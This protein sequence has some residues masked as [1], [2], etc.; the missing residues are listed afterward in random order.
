MKQAGMI[1]AV[2]GLLVCGSL[3]LFGRTEMAAGLLVGMLGSA[4]YFGLMWRQL[5]KNRDAA[6]EEAVAEL[7]GGWVERALYMGAVCGIAWFIPGV[8]FAGVLIG[9]LSMH[10]AVFVWGLVALAKSRRRR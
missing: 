8:Q 6:P 4:G 2:L 1:C 9:L 3:Q 10:A 7:Q 5:V